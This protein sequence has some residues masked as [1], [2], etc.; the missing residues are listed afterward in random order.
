MHFQHRGQAK[1]GQAHLACRDD[2]ELS[3]VD[4]RQ[5]YLYADV[6]EELHM[7]MPTMLPR[8]DEH[9][10]ALLVRLDKSLYGL[11]QAAKKWNKLLVS[12]L[13]TWGF[14]QSTIGTCMFVYT[15]PD[16]EIVRL[17]IWIDDL[18]ISSSNKQVGAR[19]AK[20]LAA[21]FEIGDTGDLEWVLGAYLHHTRDQGLAF[22]PTADK[23]ALMLYSDADWS[24]KF[25]TSGCIC[26]SHG[27][28][29]HWHTR[30]QRSVSHSTAEAEYIAASMAARE[31]VFLRELLVDLHVQL[32]GPTTMYL[33]SKS[34]IDMAFDP[35]S[36]KKTKHIL[37]DA[38]YLRDLVTREVF[39]PVHVSSAKQRADIFNKQLPRMP[40]LVLRENTTA[41][42]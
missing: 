20:D 7:R 37:R 12:F 19:F 17:T 28:A 40:Y 38:E 25:S 30:F 39:S 41:S 34:A 13:C 16:N 2:H 27:C 8:H 4:V 31:A 33:D 11:R 29:I 3:S 6:G 36:F 18:V 26:Y 42:V 35:V 9:G 32:P 24:T 5:A 14:K 22:K 1:H 15:G 21:T 10:N 23:T